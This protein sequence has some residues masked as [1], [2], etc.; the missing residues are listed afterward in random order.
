MDAAAAAA[1]LRALIA[2]DA[3]GADAPELMSLA[4]EAATTVADPELR[5]KLA[6]SL[7]ASLTVLKFGGILGQDIEIGRRQ[8]LKILDA[9]DTMRSGPPTS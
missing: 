8:A 4:D 6:E 9:L 5:G 3:A 1:R 2:G 7:I